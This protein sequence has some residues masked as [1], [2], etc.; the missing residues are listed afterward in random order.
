MIACPRAIDD[1]RRLANLTI[2]DPNDSWGIYYYLSALN[3]LKREGCYNAHSI[4]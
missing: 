4:R 1:F 3:A 2:D